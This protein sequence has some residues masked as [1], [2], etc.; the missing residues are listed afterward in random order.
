VAINEA[1]A[2]LFFR[3]GYEAT[4]LRMVASEVGIQV[5]SLYNHISGKDELLTTI[6]TEVI[7]DLLRSLD[8]AVSGAKDA[9]SALLAAIDCH[10]RFHA[11]HRRETFIGNSELRALDPAAR[12]RVLGLRRQYE[13]NLRE[14]VTAAAAEA[15]VALLDVRLQ[16]YSILALGTHI[17]SWFQPSHGDL[18][19]VVDVYTTL[20][21][22]ELAI[23][24]PRRRKR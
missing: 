23:P 1:A 16:V 4:T 24:V 3:H 6:M 13:L 7:E 19:H 12:D 17:A 8:E 14:L 10:I 22:R 20:V 2:D 9:R 18:D 21:F 15:G 11:N 5:G